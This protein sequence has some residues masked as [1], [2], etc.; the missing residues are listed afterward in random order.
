MRNETLVM[1]DPN[2]KQAKALRL[3]NRYVAYG[4]ARGGG[5]S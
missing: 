1:P 3:K 4:G 2:A 5:K